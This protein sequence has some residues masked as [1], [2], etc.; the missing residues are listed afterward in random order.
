MR[1]DQKRHGACGHWLRTYKDGTL[2]SH[3]VDCHNWQCSHC[4]HKILKPRLLRHVL[5][6]AS[7]KLW[8]FTCP[9]D[10]ASWTKV[11]RQIRGEY[12]W[13]RVGGIRH[14]FVDCDGKGEP[15][16]GDGLRVLLESLVE[17]IDGKVCPFSSSRAFAM[18]TPKNPSK[19][20][21][22]LGMSATTNVHLQEAATQLSISCKSVG[23]GLLLEVSEP[24]VKTLLGMAKEFWRQ[25]KA[26]SY[27]TL[28]NV[29]KYDSSRDDSH[30][31]RTRVPM[32]V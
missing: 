12:F 4:V 11:Y 14:V 15:R 19:G 7:R 5:S 30:P 22:S 18:H 9:D 13:L 29:P 6:I 25:D 17:D 10:T 32:R 26:K 2:H 3:P 21:V 31:M 24:M 28:E 8:H 1:P 27:K 23:L 20:F 16:H